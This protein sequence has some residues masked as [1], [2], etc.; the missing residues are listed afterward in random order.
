MSPNNQGYLSDNYIVCMTERRGGSERIYR[1]TCFC[2][3]SDKDT[4]A[5]CNKK[6]TR[7]RS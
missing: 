5:L 6:R 2:F 3:I 1:G 4:F 7:G